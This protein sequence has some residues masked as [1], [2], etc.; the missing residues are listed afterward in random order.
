L[1]KNEIIRFTKPLLKLLDPVL[2]N[3]EACGITRLRD[4]KQIAIS[5]KFSEILGTTQAIAT[6][7]NMK[8]GWNPAHLDECNRRIRSED[9]FTLTYESAFNP[10]QYGR[11]TAEILLI[12]DGVEQ[13]RFNVNQGWDLLDSFPE[14]MRI[15][16][17]F[18]W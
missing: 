12:D 18:D 6:G 17:R 16:Q 11:M 13:Y 8:M 10:Q 9:R 14:E 1:P 3:D 2:D 4:Q 15:L 5:D 7:R